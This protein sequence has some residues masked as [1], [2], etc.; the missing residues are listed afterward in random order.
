MLNRTVV[1]SILSVMNIA[2]FGLVATRFGLAS[3]NN[4]L[5]IVSVFLFS[6]AVYRLLGMVE[7]YRVD[8]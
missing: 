1:I 3:L 6:L 4:W 5:L 7:G 2:L 8:S